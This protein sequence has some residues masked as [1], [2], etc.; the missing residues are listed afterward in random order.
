MTAAVW[1][2]RQ[3][4][5][6]VQQPDVASDVQN[7]PLGTRMNASNAGVEFR[8]IYGKASAALAANAAATFDQATGAIAAGTASAVDGNIIP[9]VAINQFAWMKITSEV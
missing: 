8:L 3:P 5:A 4:V 2:I 1:T 9:A 7:H 6:G